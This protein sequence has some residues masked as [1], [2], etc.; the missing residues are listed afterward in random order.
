MSSLCLQPISNIIQKW[1]GS[2]VNN[3]NTLENFCTQRQI[4]SFWWFLW[5]LGWSCAISLSSFW[6]VVEVSFSWQTYFIGSWGKIRIQLQE[7][8]AVCHN[9][10]PCNGLPNFKKY[11]EEFMRH[12]DDKNVKYDL[13][14]QNTEYFFWSLA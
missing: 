2:L 5:I 3:H 8:I 7:N 14:P 9:T 1:I 12:P 10:A 11:P 13:W 4:G 6:F